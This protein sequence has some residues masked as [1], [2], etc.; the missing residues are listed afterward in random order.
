MSQQ[1]PVPPPFPQR[2]LDYQSPRTVQSLDYSPS[3]RFWMALL[4]GSVVSALVRIIGGPFMFKGTG[5]A[6]MFFAFGLL[7]LKFLSF[8]AC[9]FM[10]RWRMFGVGLFLSMVTGFMIFFGVCLT[11]IA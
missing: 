11:Q 6:L 2:P 1:P 7:G 3:R 10:E 4:I 8:I 5:D 9:M